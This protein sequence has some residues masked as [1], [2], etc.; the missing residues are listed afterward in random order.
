[1]QASIPFQHARYLG[2]AD[3]D[4]YPISDQYGPD[5]ERFAFLVQSDT[6]NL[7]ETDDKAASRS[8][9][10]KLVGVPSV[11]LFNI[12]DRITLNGEPFRL[13]E[14]RDMSL[15][16]FPLPFEQPRLAGLGALIVERQKA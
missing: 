10:R 9:I 13:E 6:E 12:Y 15:S 4:G 5:V 2:D 11:T 14:I 3:V 16:P 7:I 1:V 8:I